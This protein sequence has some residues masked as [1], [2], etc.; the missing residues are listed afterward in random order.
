MECN[1]YTVESVPHVLVGQ[2]KRAVEFLY[3]P[4]MQFVVVTG[5]A[6]LGMPKQWVNQKHSTRHRSHCY[7][8]GMEYLSLW[9]RYIHTV[10]SC[11]G[12]E[13]MTRNVY[14]RWT[15]FAEGIATYIP[16]LNQWRMDGRTENCLGKSGRYSSR[17]VVHYVV[18]LVAGKVPKLS[19]ID[20]SKELYS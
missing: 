20:S 12:H 18:Y 14:S 2:G 5:S 6:R 8:F 7:I 16:A 15:D 4:R 17:H 9:V 3:E 11:E 19:A 10:G 1:V 13:S